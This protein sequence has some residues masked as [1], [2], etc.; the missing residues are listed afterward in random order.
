MPCSVWSPKWDT[1]TATGV[2]PLDLNVNMRNVW[3]HAS[4]Q[5]A[6]CQSLVR[7][8]VNNVRSHMLRRYYIVE[9]LSFRDQ[10]KNRSALI[11]LETRSAACDMVP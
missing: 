5:E 9:Q 7:H 2:H 11:I 4:Q 10:L 8:H 1:Y 6:S 3:I